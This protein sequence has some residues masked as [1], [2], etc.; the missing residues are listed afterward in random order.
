MMLIAYAQAVA[1]ECLQLWVGL[2][3]TE[4]PPALD[5]QLN[6][7][8]VVPKEIAAVQPIRDAMTGA[9]AKPINHRGIFRIAN[10]EPARPYR[11]VITAG[12]E[13]VSLL[14]RTLPASVP[15]TL[16]GSFNILL[17]S[18]YYQP[19][20]A[21]GLLGTIA[22][23]IRVRPDL[24]MMLGDQI[25]GDLPLFEDL[26]DDEAGVARKLGD[27]YRRNWAS[28]QIGTGG[29]GPVL[30]RAPVVC[31]ADDHEFW[32]NYPFRQTQLP[33]TWTEGGRDQWQ[34]AAL[35]LYEDY[36]VS[37]AGA[38][39]QRINVDPLQILVV[40]MR[41]HRDENFGHLM[42]PE[43][44]Q[45]IKQWRSDL[46]DA[47][48][49]GQPAFGL[50]ASG[51]ALFVAAAEESK[52][53]SVD[54]EMANY[55]QFSAEFLPEL[56]QLADEGIPVVYVTGDVHWGRVS[57]GI[58]LRSDRTLLY[59]V[60]SSPSRLI[61]VPLADSAKETLNVVKGL[62]GKADP[63]PRHSQP[64]RVPDRFGSQRRFQ[65]RFDLERGDALAQRGD[66]IAIMSFSRAGGGINFSVSYYGITPDKSLAQSR[67]TRPYEL[68]II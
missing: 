50:L 14:T 68:R 15:Q 32:N 6:E 55:A 33:K 57:Q 16:D 27:K 38:G 60:I 11:V 37:V 58:D 5:F 12:T 47:K 20:D 34:E 36:Q 66:Q 8:P 52:K 21:S 22:S 64:Q 24:T 62:F 53:R 65:L 2:F 18:C 10:L 39:A 28:S 9:G 42:Q 54:A 31:V 29:L 46:I 3:D 48:R 13:R 25:Y 23:Q 56:D 61:R 41:C 63:W 7:Q 49:H 40:D 35:A 19:E 44:M 59:E 4:A 17:C 1:S 30:G 43:T 51:Q 45:T 26:P 67:S